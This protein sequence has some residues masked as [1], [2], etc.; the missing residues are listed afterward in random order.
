MRHSYSN[1]KK[2]RALLTARHANE[3]ATHLCGEFPAISIAFWSRNRNGNTI[4]AVTGRGAL[5]ATL[6]ERDLLPRLDPRTLLVTDRH[7]AYRAYTRKHKIEHEAINLC[8]GVRVRRLS[9]RT[10][11]AQNANANHGCF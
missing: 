9:S 2:D 11:R 10:I 5:T 8:A 1:R 6:L 3:A 4:D 7:T